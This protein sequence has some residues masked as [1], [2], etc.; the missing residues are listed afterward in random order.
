[1][2]I[3]ADKAAGGNPLGSLLSRIPEGV[4]TA[5]VVLA[6]SAGSFALGILYER[7]AGEGQGAKFG[8]FEEAP[9]PEVLGVVSTASAAP[10]ATSGAFVA[11]KNGEKYYLPSC[12]GAKR[13]KEENK[14]WFPTREAAEA[15]GYEPAANCKG[16]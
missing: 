16:L 2:P 8:S 9:V 10:P 6:A 15:S 3:I 13:I 12:S 1:M 14:V 11:S 5:A 7:E 4:L